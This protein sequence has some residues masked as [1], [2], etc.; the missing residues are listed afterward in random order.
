MIHTSDSC[1]LK[2]NPAERS[3]IL[4]EVLLP[5]S[6]LGSAGSAVAST[7]AVRATLCPPTPAEFLFPALMI[8]LAS[9]LSPGVYY[10]CGLARYF[11]RLQHRV[12]HLANLDAFHLDL[13]PQ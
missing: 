7:V 3:S 1:G 6:G 5:K 12:D 8:S 2:S 13:R 9:T 4:R 10:A 11:D